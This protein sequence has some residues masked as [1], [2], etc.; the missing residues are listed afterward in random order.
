MDLK[1]TWQMRILRARTPPGT[2]LGQERLGG[3]S[4]SMG[5]K[6]PGALAGHPAEPTLGW[7]GTPSPNRY[8]QLS[9]KNPRPNQVAKRSV[10]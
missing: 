3:P 10:A 7:Q 9:P 1:G 4:A 5:L 6:E 8:L 2:H